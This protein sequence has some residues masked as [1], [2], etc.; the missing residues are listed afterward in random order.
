[1]LVQKLLSK[2]NF[3]DSCVLK[4]MH[5][6][7]NLVLKIDFCCWKQKNYKTTDNEMKEIVLKFEQV[8]NYI[9]DSDK[10]EKEID[11]DEILRFDCRKNTVEIV[12][13][14]NVVSVMTFD[15]NDVIIC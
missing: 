8:N 1:M 15:C 14:N 9:W 4:L 2:Y 13:Y 6:E 11:C 5:E 3:H 12:L 10:S 7:N